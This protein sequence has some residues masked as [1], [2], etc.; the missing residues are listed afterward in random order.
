MKIKHFAGYGCVNARKCKDSLPS[1]LH[2]EVE[3]NHEWGLVRED[4][5]DLFQWIVSRF[6]KRFPDYQ[7]WHMR[8]P[9]IDIRPGWRTDPN[10]GVI[11]TCDYYFYY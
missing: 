7:S 4:D 2:I 9:I 6:D 11:D 3:G 10:L 5:Y 8:D 1:M